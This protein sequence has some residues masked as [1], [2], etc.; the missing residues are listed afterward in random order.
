MRSAHLPHQ[1]TSRA[2]FPNGGLREILRAKYKLRILWDLRRGSRRYGELR[3][4]LGLGV[5]ARKAIAPRV[6][7]R[8]LKSLARL[9]LIQRRRYD[10]MPLKVEYRLTPLGRSL[11]PVI[12]KIL[13]WK[14]RHRARSH[15]ARIARR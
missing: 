7:S 2:G 13:Q 14:A 1:N 10:V 6:L 11:L 3:K 5:G 8:E 15:S 9:G 4:R 12:T